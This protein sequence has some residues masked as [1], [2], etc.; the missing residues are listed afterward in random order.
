MT[1]TP[2]DPATVLPD[3][4]LTALRGGG[5][6]IDLHSPPRTEALVYDFDAL[7]ALEE[8]Y[9][10]LQAMSKAIAEQVFTHLPNALAAGLR[11]TGDPSLTNGAALRRRLVLADIEQYGQAFGAAFVAAFGSLIVAADGAESGEAEG[12]TSPAPSLGDAGTAP[13]SSTS[14]SDPATS[15]A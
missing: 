1:G 12:P 9:G 2:F 3:M 10:T 7:A 14:D 5:T 11:H 8:Q 4:D 15:G 13:L 6:V